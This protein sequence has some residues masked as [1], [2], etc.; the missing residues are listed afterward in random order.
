M[1]TAS[2]YYPIAD[3]VQVYESGHRRFMTLAQ[4]KAD[5]DKFTLYAERTA[6]KGGQIRVITVA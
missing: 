6:E 3:E 1:R 4:A 5:Y 2:G